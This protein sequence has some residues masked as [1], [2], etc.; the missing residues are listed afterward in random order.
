MG[1]KLFPQNNNDENAINQDK[2]KN[3]KSEYFSIV[4][5]IF[6]KNYEQ[7]FDE[8]RIN[9]NMT[10]CL[11]KKTFNEVYDLNEVGNYSYIYWLDYL[12][13]FLSVEQKNEEWA[14]EMIEKLDEE[15]FLIENKYL[16]QFFFKEFFITTEPQ[17]ISE[18]K[19]DELNESLDDI[20][21]NSNSLKISLNNNNLNMMRNLGGTFGPNSPQSQKEE[22]ESDNSSVNDETEKKYKLLRNQV[23]KYIYI[24]KEHIIHKDH[25]INRTIQ[26]FEEAWVKHV[27]KKLQFIEN[28]DDSDN[29]FHNTN[30]LID[31][32]TKQLQDFVIIMQ[33]CLKLF[34]C[35]AIDYSCFINEKDELIN[36]LTTIIFR[37]GKIYQ[38]IFK[39]QKIKLGSISSD[40][41][42]KYIELKKITPQVL[43]IEKQFCLN[44]ETLNM[45]EEILEKEKSSYEKE[46][47]KDEKE[48]DDN[49][50]T[51]IHLENQDK[52]NIIIDITDEKME[53]R[54]IN[55]ILMKIKEKKKK[56]SKY[57]E[58]DMNDDIQVDI[59]FGS[60]NNNIITESYYNRPGSLYEDNIIGSILTKSRETMDND[61]NLLNKN[62]TKNNGNNIL[63]LNGNINDSFDENDNCK[64]IRDH[65][66]G[67]KSITQINFVKVF[68]RISFTKDPE[69][70]EFSYFPYE[71]AIQLLKQIEK[72]KAPFEKMLIF[73]SLSNEIKNC[74]DDYWKDMED[75]IKNDL[76]GV[77]A[78]QL[79]TIFVYIISKAQI[80]DILVHC[81]LI[82]LFTT[83]MTKSSMIGYYYSN[84]EASVNYIQTLKS[85]KE[86][87]KGSGIWSSQ[88][89]NY[90]YDDD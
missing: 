8:K 24:F 33:I 78:E 55:N 4:N 80:E 74:I 22:S 89:S 51:N 75:Y 9:D 60:D 47:N 13:H 39:L 45:Q 27:E 48:K 77:E 58:S 38:T 62:K 49:L 84:A 3:I 28:F 6:R 83:T 73:A 64:I 63:F 10:I 59:D 53:I 52:G 35:K 71:T 31:E 88:N 20:F 37:T 44:I 32:L 40:M 42:N 57:R 21:S 50:N 18:S 16:S 15:P 54:K 23:K 26:I 81:K 87:F 66:E 17:C 14:N 34:Y 61:N 7:T 82:Q 69:K 25:P 2:F 72:Y 12:Y 30:E 36:L 65:N 46:P 70:K 29:D 85:V 5:Q 67:R 68:E 19:G 43:G 56:I 1:S 86:L 90:N 41:K 79:M 76:L 11:E